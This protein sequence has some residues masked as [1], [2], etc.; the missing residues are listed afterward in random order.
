MD[1]YQKQRGLNK[2]AAEISFGAE[3]RVRDEA[4]IQN[5][6]GLREDNL[7]TRSTLSD[8]KGQELAQSNTFKTAQIDTY[9]KKKDIAISRSK[10]QAVYRAEQRQL[11]RDYKEMGGKITRAK[12]QGNLRDD[13]LDNSIDKLRSERF[14]NTE[15]DKN[16]N[17]IFQ[18]EQAG[19]RDEQSQIR[20][21]TD[22][23]LNDI[24]REYQKSKSENLSQRMDQY[25]E[26]LRARGTLAAQGRR[27]QS[28][29]AQQQSA[30][31]SYGRQQAQMV[32][33]MVYASQDK[34]SARA[35]TTSK[36]DFDIA[37]LDRSATKNLAGRR[38][39]IIARNLKTSN[40]NKDISSTRKEKTLNALNTQGEVSGLKT[41]RGNL[42]DDKRIN[43]AR[44]QKRDLLSKNERSKLDAAL[45]ATRSEVK[46]AKQDIKNRMGFTQEEW[47]LNK[48]KF[49]ASNTSAQ[50]AYQAAKNKIR[51]DRYGADLAAKANV[52]QKPIRPPSL[53]KPRTIPTT[54]FLEPMKPQK[55]P[56]PIKGALGKTS[57]WNDIGDVANVGLKIAGFF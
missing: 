30:L 14:A 54:K 44:N 8:L 11:D 52:M 6:F 27:G 28:A 16:D 2:A 26:S 17:T 22:I 31:A 18:Q 33:S 10:D 35:S 43:S 42:R 7:S 21:Q 45:D 5:M 23:Q 25:A 40:I 50:K 13:V 36:R 32:D 1:D 38:K 20:D 41:D 34:A 47:K 3:K 29:D 51:L 9:L 12:Q 39:Q 57:I 46:L 15:T 49:R 48:D 24:D 4:L 56:K 53:P 55:P 19:I 37:Q